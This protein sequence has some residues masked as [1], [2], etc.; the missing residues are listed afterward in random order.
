MIRPSAP[1]P[2]PSLVPHPAPQRI[3]LHGVGR[4]GTSWLMKIFDHHPDV[5]CLHEPEMRLPGK[6][7]PSLNGPSFTDETLTDYATRIFE[8]RDIWAVRKRPILTKSFRSPVQH[9]AR[10]A[11]IYGASLIDLGLRRMGQ[12]NLRI[13]TPDMTRC[14]PSHELVKSVA[15]PYPLDRLVMANPHIR[16]VFIIRHPC[17]MA[18]SSCRGQ[19]MGLYPKAYLPQRPLLARYFQFDAP[20][21][22]HEGMFSRLE[23]L[24]YRWSVFN[25]MAVET[26][27]HAPNLRVIRYEDL[28][29]DPLELA[30]E[31][32]DWVGLDWHGRVDTFLHRSLQMSGDATGYHDLQRN[33]KVAASKWREK[34]SLEDQNSIRRIAMR[35]PAAALYEDLQ[36]APLSASA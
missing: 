32:F 9:Q 24:S 26:A 14:R 13:S 23:L 1:H 5:Q 28:C 10:T 20:E 3:W 7:A 34:L 21:H 25:G 15:S 4:S 8:G 11:Y 29:A 31:L 30:Q 22:L 33:P 16:F 35:S 18:L 27:A 12:R 2:A 19:D 6:P 36:M 17:G